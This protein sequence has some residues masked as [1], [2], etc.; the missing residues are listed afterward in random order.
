[1]SGEKFETSETREELISIAEAIRARLPTVEELRRIDELCALSPAPDELPFPPDK[2][3]NEQRRAWQV[4]H[5]NGVVAFWM[6]I[7]RQ[8]DGDDA[9][10]NA[11]ILAVKDVLIPHVQRVTG[12][13]VEAIKKRMGR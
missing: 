5:G 12:P 1:M 2:L 6:A 4:E 13:S 10:R 7:A 3:S 11:S 8:V 9:T